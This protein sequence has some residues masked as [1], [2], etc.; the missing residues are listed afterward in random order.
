VDLGFGGDPI[1]RHAIRVDM[2]E[3]YAFTGNDPVQLGGPAERLHWFAD[4]VLDFVYSS[5]LLEDYLD[6]EAVLREWLRVLKPGG[7][8]IIFCP[9]EQ[10]YRKH[11]D[12]TGQVYNTHH[13]HTDFSLEFV[14]AVLT[15]LG[16]TR[17]IHQTPLVDEYSWELVAEKLE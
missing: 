2:P 9:D 11:C 6:T 16:G 8:L 4:D 15:R 13:V 17:I 3:P 14:K 10:I 12:A 5:H 1:V 7:R